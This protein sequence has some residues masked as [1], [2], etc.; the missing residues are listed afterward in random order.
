M[1]SSN[2]WR[3][4]DG[5][6]RCTNCVS[7]SQYCPPVPAPTY[8]YQ[9]RECYRE[10]NSQN[11]LDMHMQV[12]RPRNVSCPVCGEQR[13]LSPANAIQHV[14]SGYCTGCL[15]RD[16]ARQQIYQYAQGQRRMQPFMTGTPL[17][18][19]GSYNSGVPDLPYQ[20]PQ[21]AKSFRQL[22]QLYQHQD[23][24]HSMRMLGYI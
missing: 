13:F 22:S 5:Y 17:L 15:G 20:C 23:N 18:A 10:F 14:E 4:G 3:K 2:Q 24:K 6:S 11:E 19:N 12:H 1:F 16:N 8:F 7:G 9:C 21:C